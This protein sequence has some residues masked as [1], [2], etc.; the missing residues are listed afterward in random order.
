VWRYIGWDVLGCYP[1]TASPSRNPKYPT[2]A[3]IADNVVHP[4]W[5]ALMYRQ[6]DGAIDMTV[7][8]LKTDQN[9]KRQGAEHRLYQ[10]SKG[11]RHRG[12]GWFGIWHFPDKKI[13]LNS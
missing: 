9:E 6:A 8:E 7:Q 1:R 4:P 5:D 13:K 11:V 12:I 3:A 10:H 2:T